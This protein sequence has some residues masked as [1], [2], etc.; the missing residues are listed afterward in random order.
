MTNGCMMVLV[1]N[2]D[3]LQ[4][5]D[6]LRGFT[7][8][9]MTFVNASIY[10]HDVGG[11]DVASL[12]LHTPWTGFSA[13]DAVFPGFVVIA[14][15]SM[16]LALENS[17]APE[18]RRVLLVKLVWRAVK[19]LMVGFLVSNLDLFRGNVEADGGLRI[20]GV[21]QRLGM[22][23]FCVGLSMIYQTATRRLVVAVSI[24]VLYGGL[25]L[26]RPPDGGYDLST[27]GLDIAAWIDRKVLP[28]MLYVNG[29]HG[30][31][32]EGILST[33]PAIAQGL[34]GALLIAPLRS[35]KTLSAWARLVGLGMTLVIGG[36][37]LGALEPVCKGLWS[38]AFV[39]ISTGTTLVAALLLIGATTS[40]LVMP[41]LM[42]RILMPVGEGAI[43]AYLLQEFGDEYLDYVP[44]DL[45]EDDGVLSPRILA[46]LVA[47]GF[48][49]TIWLVTFVVRRTGMTMRI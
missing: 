48:T 49:A 7:I 8:L 3:R 14:G 9:A 47:A 44:V 24:L 16:A 33:L 42:R 11:A 32:P 28:D 5:L 34:I 26:I 6:M 23:S 20:M 37:A 19:L 27:P 41:M 29:P 38:P 21:L 43:F 15:M 30:Y 2:A 31:D 4:W 45:S 35:C 36:L 13:A 10:L 22:V 18:R 12:L 40:G 25:L 1:P 17:C 46:L 39:L